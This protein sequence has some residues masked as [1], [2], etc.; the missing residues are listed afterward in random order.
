MKSR[1]LLATAL[2]LPLVATAEAPKVHERLLDNG[3]KVLVKEDH[4][5]PIVTSQVWYKVGSSYEHGGLTGVS[6]LL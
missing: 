1:L 2:A 5:A 3:L 6:H 4:R